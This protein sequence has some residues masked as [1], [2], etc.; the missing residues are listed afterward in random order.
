MKEIDGKLVD[1]FADKF[2]ETFSRVVATVIFYFIK[3]CIR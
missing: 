1:S 2:R 3:F